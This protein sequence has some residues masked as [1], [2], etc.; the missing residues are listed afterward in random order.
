M[1]RKTRLREMTP[2]D[3]PILEE[4]LREQ[5]ERDGTS[6]HLPQIFDAHGKRLSRIPLA[7]AA[8]DLRSGEVR[9]GHVFEQTLEQTTYGMD[10]EATVCSMH[11][12][13]AV[14]FLLR[15][16]GYRDLH[17]FVPASAPE[18]EH[19]LKHI[20]RMSKTGFT[21]FYRLLD[22]AEN[23][24]LRAFYGKERELEVVSV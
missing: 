17:L 15:E 14:M 8:V 10:S 16:R 22:P 4:K 1:K 6:Y 5:N 12:Q 7:L 19:G 2:G 24:A 11:E 3:I 9:Q 23:E 13:G 20:Y 18:M 21:H